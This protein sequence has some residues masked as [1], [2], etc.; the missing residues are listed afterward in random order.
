VLSG[1]FSSKDNVIHAGEGPIYA[2]RWRRS[3][4]AWA[5]DLGVKLYDC[6]TSEPIS[7]IARPKGSPPPELFRCNLA[8][9]NDDTLLIGWADSVKVGVVKRRPK[10]PSRNIFT[11][12][13]VEMAAMFQ[14]DFYICGIAPY[15]DHIVLLA[16]RG[17]QE[18]AERAASRGILSASQSLTHSGAGVTGGPAGSIEQKSHAPFVPGKV[19]VLC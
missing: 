14:T 1:W 18:E 8:W 19:G 12:R 15:G 17:Q 9:A 11:T 10:D 2:V 5:N 4:I 13:Y 6:E 7:Y 3:I 16:Y